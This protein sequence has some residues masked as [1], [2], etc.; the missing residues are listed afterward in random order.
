MNCHY[1]LQIRLTEGC[2][3]GAVGGEMDAE[4]INIFKEPHLLVDSTSDGIYK[5][6]E[7]VVAKLKVL[8]KPLVVLAIAGPGRTGKSYLLNRLSCNTKGIV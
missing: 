2:L 1:S 6:N 3:E 4:D 8:K 7:E 5:I